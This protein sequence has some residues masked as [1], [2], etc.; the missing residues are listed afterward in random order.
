VPPLLRG[1]VGGAMSDLAKL[2]EELGRDPDE[3]IPICITHRGEFRATVATVDDVTAL[4]AACADLDCWYGA[5]PLHPRVTAG[6]GHARDVV[7]VR[8][9]YADLDVKPGGMPTYDAAADVIDDLS[10]MLGTRPVA[11]VQSGHGLQPHWAVE[12]G[13]DTDWPDENDPRHGDATALL[14]RWGR[15]VRHVAERHGGSVDGVF[16]LDRIL[17][18]PGTTNR[19]DPDH[20][21][22]TTIGWN[23]GGP[24]TL[25]RVAETLTEYGVK[26]LP[27]DRDTLGE[28]VSEPGSW[29]WAERTCGYVATMVTNW[30][31]DQPSARHPWLV[32]QATRLAAAHRNGCITQTDYQQ[33]ARRLPERFRWLLANTQERRDEAK[34]EITDALDWGVER[35]ATRTDEQISKE[36]GRHS[37]DQQTAVADDDEAFWSARNELKLIREFARAKLA[38]PWAVLMAALAR[39]ICQIPAAIVLPD[40]IYGPASLNLTI[41]LVAQSGGGKGGSTTVARYAVDIGTPRFQPHTLG[42]GQGIAHGY[43]RWNA[44]EKV[45]EQVADS[46]LFTVEEVDHLA[47]HHNQNGSTT[48]AELRRFGMGQRLG[49]LYADP[50]RRVEVSAH[51]YRGAIIVSVQPT[52][53]AVILDATDA[54]TPQRFLWVPTIDAGQPDVAPE[55]PAPFRWQP[56][57]AGS[58]KHDPLT[59]LSPI[60]V[61]STAVEMIRQGQRDRNAGRGDPLDGHALLTRERVAAA[62][63]IL[64]GHYGITE[65]DWTLA[66]IVM[67]VSDTTRKTVVGALSAK[68]TETNR[69]RAEAEA[70]RAIL[71]G[72]R[73]EEEATKRVARTVMRILTTAGDWVARA[74]LRKAI[75]SRDR[76]RFDEVIQ[77]LLAAGQI[78]LEETAKGARYRAIGESP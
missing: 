9:L 37:H 25:T 13:D 74:D 49:H 57:S 29:T 75:N 18:A 76:G 1:S 48:L 28:V 12:H 54:G 47:A 27:G 35:A 45:V 7:G 11:V 4:A 36:L 15:L 30:A 73:V 33:A 41:A 42:T 5:A 53:A 50:T 46:V 34:G 55:Q 78:Q 24:V 31:G 38:S 61:C 6:K 43:A 69:Q 21:V 10:A 32:S 22:R 14:R 62:L 72:D 71:I 3:R 60:P 19:K 44:K 17:R 20:P 2:L 65:D 67:A 39:V 56:P 8:E 63:G 52:R 16:N 64:N 68:A 59:G 70:T 40:I 58:L 23:S 26:D 77:R 66:G 51:S